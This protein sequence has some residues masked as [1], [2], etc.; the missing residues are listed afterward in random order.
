MGTRQ[1]KP[2]IRPRQ[3]RRVWNAEGPFLE[4]GARGKLLL[5]STVVEET[6][7]GRKWRGVLLLAASFVFRFIHSMLINV[8]TTSRMSTNRKG[9]P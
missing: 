6:G 5:L 1:S 8:L 4:R 7:G 2:E 9:K 3:P